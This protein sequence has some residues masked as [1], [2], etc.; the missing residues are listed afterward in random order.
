MFP[1]PWRKIS[2]THYLGGTFAFTEKKG[3]KKHF[4]I[5]SFPLLSIHSQFCCASS[6]KSDWVSPRGAE[7]PQPALMKS[8][9]DNTA[10]SKIRHKLLSEIH[11]HTRLEAFNPKT[12]PKLAKRE[13]IYKKQPQKAQNST[14]DGERALLARTEGCIMVPFEF[15][16][17]AFLMEVFL[18]KFSLELIRC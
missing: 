4:F 2:K 14:E 10:G 11:T 12:L 6:F 17:V 8:Q 18:F 3:K 9:G 13:N 7:H 5:H 15:W 16:R 1:K